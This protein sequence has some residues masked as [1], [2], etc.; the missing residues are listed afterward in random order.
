M[1]QITKGNMDTKF[2]T[3]SCPKCGSSEQTLDQELRFGIEYK[4]KHCGSTSV[5][6]IN[7]RL[8]MPLP[9]EKVCLACGRVADRDARFCQCGQPL[10]RRCINPD[11]LR[12]FPVDHLVC[13]Y[14]GWKQEILPNSE[15]GN[16][17]EFQ[18][19][20]RDSLIRNHRS[21]TCF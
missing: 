16:W 7:N 12:E 13:D 1:M 4:C 18:H 5:L 9:G 11:C 15:E 8:Y 6:I 21:T 10:V 19:A 20:M 2:V 17:L 14:C 3:L